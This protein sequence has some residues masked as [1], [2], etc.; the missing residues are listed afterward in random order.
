MDGP[1]L[2]PS[3]MTVYN[4]TYYYKTCL[5][6]VDTGPLQKFYTFAIFAKVFKYPLR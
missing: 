5:M 6:N 1:I 3:I 2:V 4:I